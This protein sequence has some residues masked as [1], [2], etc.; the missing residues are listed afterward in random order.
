M[1]I[2]S[3]DI[4]GVRNTVDKLIKRIKYDQCK[5]D[6]NPNHIKYLNRIRSNTDSYISE[7]VE[8]IS[9]VLNEI[10]KSLPPEIVRKN[11]ARGSHEH[12][13]SIVKGAYIDSLN[14]LHTISSSRVLNS[15]EE[16]IKAFLIEVKNLSDLEIIHFKWTFEARLFHQIPFE[17]ADILR[18]H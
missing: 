9:D 5:F 6:Q 14:K 12:Y 3:F 1:D 13:L 7:R 8:K 2:S 17:L 4:K 10:E 15:K 18:N 16:E 11:F